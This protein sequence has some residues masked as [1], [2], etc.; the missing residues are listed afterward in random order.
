MTPDG[1]TNLTE[2]A[3]RFVLK[4]RRPGVLLAVSDFLDPDGFETP[5]NLLA[6]AQMDLFCVHVMA[7]EEAEPVL[8]GDF[9]LIDS[10]SGEK[11]DVTASRRLVEN[12]LKTVRGFCSSL[13]QF[14]AARGA[15]YLFATTDLPFEALVLQYLRTAGM[16]R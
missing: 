7:K 10:E 8:T 9:L 12:Y 5:L 1:K 2:T 15:S 16:L 13:Q 4:N 3:R 6:G 14:C 11:L